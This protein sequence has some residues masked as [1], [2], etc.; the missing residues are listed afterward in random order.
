MA[1]KLSEYRQSILADILTAKKYVEGI[2]NSIHEPILGLDEQ[3]KILFANDEAL[4]VLNLKR[5]DVIGKAA[6]EK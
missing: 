1:A 5:E 6:A 2:V 4:S 3:R